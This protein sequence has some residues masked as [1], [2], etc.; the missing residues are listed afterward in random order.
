MI[1]GCIVQGR[2]KKNANTNLRKQQHPSSLGYIKS[3]NMI[4]LC[5]LAGFPVRAQR[6]AFDGKPSDGAVIATNCHV[7]FR[8]RTH[9]TPAERQEAL[10]LDPRV[11]VHVKQPGRHDEDPRGQVDR[12]EDV[13]E[14]HRFAGP[15]RQHAGHQQGDAE[16]DEVR[17]ATC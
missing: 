4:N 8:T 12:V 15:E 11:G 1:L 7:A 2:A 6:V 14:E 5:G 13:V 17:R 9:P 16:R 10:V 3:I